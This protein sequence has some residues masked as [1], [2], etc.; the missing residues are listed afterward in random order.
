MGSGQYF[1][2]P[3]GSGLGPNLSLRVPG[4][5]NFVYTAPP[6]IRVSQHA[7]VKLAICKIRMS[8]V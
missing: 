4:L 1:K 6:E 5:F 8:K 7:C 2:W 3:A